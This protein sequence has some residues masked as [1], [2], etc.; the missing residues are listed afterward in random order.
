MMLHTNDAIKALCLLVLDKKI[1]FMFS[2]VFFMFFMFFL[3]KTCDPRAGAPG[4]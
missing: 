1:V 2:L 3:C 4:A